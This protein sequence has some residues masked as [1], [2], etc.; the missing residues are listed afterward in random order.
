MAANNLKTVFCLLCGVSG[1]FIR[2]L[3][4][5][6]QQQQQLQENINQEQQ[7]NINKFTSPPPTPNSTKRLRRRKHIYIKQLF[8]IGAGKKKNQ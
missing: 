3:F 2:N 1:D 4:W 5:Q 6:H 8:F 7:Q